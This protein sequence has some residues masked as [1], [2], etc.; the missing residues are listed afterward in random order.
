MKLI[1]IEG[2]MI[3]PLIIRIGNF[4]DVRFETKAFKTL[5]LF[6]KSDYAHFNLS[7]QLPILE[8]SEDVRVSELLSILHC[9]FEK[10]E[11][12]GCRKQCPAK[13][14]KNLEFLLTLNKLLEITHDFTLNPEE[15]KLT[16]ESI[17]KVK[18]ELNSLNEFLKFNTFL[19]GNDASSADLGLLIVSLIA[20]KVLGADFEKSFVNINR[21]LKHFLNSG[22]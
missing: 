10:S 5:K 4:L 12:Q 20:S 8:V 19:G 1:F 13:G 18:K 3:T 6:A 17:E 21:V 7:E 16:P 15:V 22:F 14:I 9:L 2:C 11:L